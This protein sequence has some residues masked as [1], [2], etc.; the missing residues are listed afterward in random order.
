MI[1]PS[2][3]DLMAQIVG[4]C[5]D[6]EDVIK[7]TFKLWETAGGDVAT[8]VPLLVEIDARGTVDGYSGIGPQV[9]RGDQRVIPAR[10]REGK[11]VGFTANK[12][13]FSFSLKLMDEAVET[14]SGPGAFR[15]FALLNQAGEIHDGW[16]NLEIDGDLEDEERALLMGTEFVLPERWQEMFS[17]RYLIT[18]IV[19]EELTKHA[20]ALKA[21][22]KRL[23]DLGYS[24]PPSPV[25]EY[26]RAPTRSVDTETLLAEV[27]HTYVIQGQWTIYYDN[28]DEG[29]TQAQKL[30]NKL[31][32]SVIPRLRYYVR[33]VEY[34]FYKHGQGVNPDFEDHQIKQTVWQRMMILSTDEGDVHLRY[35]VLTKKARV[36]A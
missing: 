5:S 9:T 15:N 22:V 24:L 11:I 25:V 35:R 26:S 34:A 36:P 2:A 16:R 28:T 29:V 27:D 18:K 30:Y 33:M 10:C 8:L 23:I 3:N 4:R 13:F 19:I 32:H 1:N 17:D 21:E 20:K 12:D 31:I 14:D 7:A 6:P